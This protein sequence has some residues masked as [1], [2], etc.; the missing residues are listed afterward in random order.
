MISI[1]R[2]GRAAISGTLILL[3]CLTAQAQQRT[4]IPP[5]T[6]ERVIVVGVPD[7]YASLAPQIAR[8][9][10][11]SPQ[12]YY[13]VIVNSTGTGQSATR[14]FADELV[15]TWRQ[16]RSKRGRSF[17]PERSVI[18]VVASRTIRSPSNP[19]PS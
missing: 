3:T 17:D 18:I 4:P 10:K 2:F 9:E 6:G 19:V 1:L 7:Q 13:V 16:P 12:T 8:L 11:T 15:E 14:D 5:F